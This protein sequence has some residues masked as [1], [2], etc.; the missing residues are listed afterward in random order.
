MNCFFYPTHKRKLKLKHLGIIIFNWN[1]NKNRTKTSIKGGTF[2]DTLYSLTWKRVLLNPE[3][4]VLNLCLLSI[5]SGCFCWGERICPT[6]TENFNVL[7]WSIYTGRKEEERP[8]PTTNSRYNQNN[9][10][11][12]EDGRTKSGRNNKNKYNF[13]FFL[14]ISLA[15][16][17]HWSDC[18]I[19]VGVL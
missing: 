18:K 4:R 12:V 17:F 19:H 3:A 6:I 5:V 14:F 11:D 13:D 16:C 1:F 8:L 2:S 15:R 9:Y 7:L 10:G